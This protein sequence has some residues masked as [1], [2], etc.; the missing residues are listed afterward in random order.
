MSILLIAVLQTAAFPF[1][2]PT[3]VPFIAIPNICYNQNLWLICP[4]PHLYCL[5]SAVLFDLLSTTGIIKIFAGHNYRW[6]IFL[7]I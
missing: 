2:Q 4:F 6:P 5:N 1:R 7:K 3:E